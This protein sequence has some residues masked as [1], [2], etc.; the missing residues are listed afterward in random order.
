MKKLA[1]LMMLI[2]CSNSFS[3]KKELRQINKLI[4]ESF[5][6]EA[7]SSLEAISALVEVSDDKIKA[8]YYLSLIHI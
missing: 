4:S 2:I 3:Q 5:F 6:T 7:E 8:Q 1:I